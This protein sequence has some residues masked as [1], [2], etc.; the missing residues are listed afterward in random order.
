MWAIAIDD[1]LVGILFHVM[2][3][4]AINLQTVYWQFL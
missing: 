2:N 3:E 1:G 4:A